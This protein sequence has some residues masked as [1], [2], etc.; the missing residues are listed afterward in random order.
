LPR[1]FEWFGATLTDLLDVRPSQAARSTPIEGAVNIPLGDLGD[2]SGELPDRSVA[3]RVADSGSEATKA[4]ALLQGAGREAGL[5]KSF[6]MGDGNGPRRMWRPNPFL[7][8]VLWQLPPARAMDLACGTGREA[9]AMSAL[10][11]DVTAIDHL[12]D[13]LQR[14][15]R[16]AARFGEAGR[17]RWLQA[18]LTGWDP[19]GPADLVTSF[20]FLDRGLI[21]RVVRSLEP[22]GSLV[23]ETFTQTHR[24]TLGRPNHEEFV[25]SAEEL[26]TLVE[27][28]ELLHLSEGWRDSGRHTVRLWARR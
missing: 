1:D 26:G 15:E 11:W 12:P 18:D 19:D 6:C 10:A 28:M 23:L 7:M 25:I 13:A 16:L 14:A 22:G 3:I 17:V 9:A 2:C 27:P 21:R 20:F 24:Q 5:T 8:E 4:V